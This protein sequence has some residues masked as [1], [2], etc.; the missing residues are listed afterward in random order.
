VGVD[1]TVPM[2]AW[3][4]RTCAIRK[5]VRK[6]TCPETGQAA[7]GREPGFLASQCPAGMRC[8]LRFKPTSKIQYP[9]QDG[10]VIHLYA[11][12]SMSNALQEPREPTLREL[13]SEVSRLRE[14][15]EDLEDLRDLLAAE[16]A[17]RGRPGIPWEEAKKEL[18]LD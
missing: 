3:E 7:L 13:A 11:E 18:N 4:I 5:V 14:R 1:S 10:K 8:A 9:F 2:K 15:V 17:A 12:N 6:K 16:H